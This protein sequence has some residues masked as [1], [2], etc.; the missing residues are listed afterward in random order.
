MLFWKGI[1]LCLA[2]CVLLLGGCAASRSEPIAGGTTNEFTNTSPE[3]PSSGQDDEN[4]AR[5]AYYEQVINDL[6]A[7]ILAM[8][9]DLFSAKTEYEE[10]LE[11]LEAQRQQSNE[12]MP[13]TYTVEGDRVTITG[14]RGSDVNVTIPA[15]ID[16]RVVV[17]IGDK[18]FLG[19]TAV[20]SIVI[21]EGVEQIGWFAFSGCISLGSISVPVSVNSICYGAF[22]NCPSSLT[23]FCVKD[24]Y[25]Q[26]YAQ[27]YGIA[28]VS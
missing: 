24:S 10:R 1:C 14:Y 18:A 6:R 19:N 7:E 2:L 25:A 3:L 4:S 5:L 20:Q 16:G 28:A 22:E 26:K 23:V 21:P 15:S 17:A 11:E 12:A 27:S 9:A 13:F 8:K